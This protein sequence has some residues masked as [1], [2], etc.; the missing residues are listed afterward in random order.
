MVVRWYPRPRRVLKDIFDYYFNVAG[1][2][3]AIKIVERI[4]D[5]GESLKKMPYRAS[6]ELL[7]EDLPGK[8]RSLRVK[9]HYKVIYFVSDEAVNIVDIWDVRQDPRRLRRKMRT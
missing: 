2:R 5:S 3:T 4:R 7:L 9:P 8:Y 6:V 1:H